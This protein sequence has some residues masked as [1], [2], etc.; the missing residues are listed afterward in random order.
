VSNKFLCFHISKAYPIAEHIVSEENWY[1]SSST[2]HLVNNVYRPVCR[3]GNT[4]QNNPTIACVDNRLQNVSTVA[5]L[6]GKESLRCIRFSEET[7][8]GLYIKVY[9]PLY[10]L[11]GYQG[12]NRVVLGSSRELKLA[13]FSKAPQAFNYIFMAAVYKHFSQDTVEVYGE[14]SARILFKD[15]EQGTI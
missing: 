1:F 12:K 5:H 14:S 2:L 3:T 7:A 8:I 13:P 9:L 15:L 11:S 10:F 6:R 4:A